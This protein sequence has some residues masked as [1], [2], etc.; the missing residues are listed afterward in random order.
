M[1]ET[2]RNLEGL[3]FYRKCHAKT[4]LGAPFPDYIKWKKEP[5]YILGQQRITIE[6]HMDTKTSSVNF[7]EDPIKINKEADLIKTYDINLPTTGQASQV[8]VFFFENDE[9]KK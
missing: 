4:D 9:G 8:C 1:I 5:K 3:Q 7:P 6:Y 2:I